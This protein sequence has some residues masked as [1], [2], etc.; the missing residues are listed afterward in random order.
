LCASTSR[1]V[2]SRRWSVRSC[3]DEAPLL[4]WG[5]AELVRDAAAE[6]A[7]AADL[8]K[9]RISS[10]QIHGAAPDDVLAGLGSVRE[11]LVH[12]QG[13]HSLP[14]RE[15]VNRVNAGF[16]SLRVPG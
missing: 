13:D 9:W 14:L 12:P 6:Q 8:P 5:T 4:I 1:H 3:L 10:V 16:L 11:R 2:F 7:S 15:A